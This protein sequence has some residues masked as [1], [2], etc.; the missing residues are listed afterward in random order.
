VWQD[1][2]DVGG[3][4]TWWDVDTDMPSQGV[5]SPHAAAQRGLGLSRES[6]SEKT[7]KPRG[8]TGITPHGRRLV[9]NGVGLLEFR[10]RT[11]NLCLFTGTF[12]SLSSEDWGRVRD[13]WSKGI[14]LFL[15]KL[16]Y[17]HKKAG[18]SSAY[19]GCVELQSGRLKETG[20]PG[21]HL[22]LVTRS[23]KSAKSDWILDK[24]EWA[25]LWRETWEDVLEGRYLWNAATRV[26]T[27]VKSAASYLGKY[28]SKGEFAVTECQ[29]LTGQDLTIPSWYVCSALIRKWVKTSTASGPDVGNYLR[30]LLN[31]DSPEIT[32]KNWV[33][34]NLTETVKVPLVCY[35]STTHR[36]WGATPPDF[37]L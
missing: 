7:R 31:E 4:E 33:F 3:S 22:H 9:R 5:K 28:L 35:G 14:D 24:E 1:F 2:E 29:Q 25:K 17:H 6:N 12:P 10:V 11:T 13:G 37:G 19:V 23:R 21:Y 20:K 32:Y 26:E 8:S 36:N 27:I 16:A 18:F 30:M 34:L 15:R